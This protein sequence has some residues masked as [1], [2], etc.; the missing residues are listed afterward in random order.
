MK[1]SLITAIY[2]NRENIHS[3][4]NSVLSQSFK[5]IEYIII[6]G[7]SND[8][9]IELIR[10]NEL[11]I[12]KDLQKFI[13]VSEPDSGIYDAINKGI[14]LASGEIIGLL[15]SDDVFYNEFVIEKIVNVFNNRNV[16]SVYGDLEYV[17]KEDLNKVFRY[18]KAGEF[19]YKILKQGWMPPHPT[20]FIKKKIYDEF[21]SFNHLFSIAADYELIMRFL[22]KNKISIAYLPEVMV[23]MRVG[24]ASNKSIKN[25]F[26][27]SFE[28]YQSLKINGIN[29]P[30]ITLFLKNI[31]KLP[32]FF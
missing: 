18:W 21:G 13:F 20:F 25:I 24:G 27:K 7:G 30:L 12:T 31:R 23:K 14:N 8:G 32:Q 22:Y 2:N 9:S 26:R 5:D 28:D 19:K 6:D 11:Q 4:I 16:D 29:T 15:H 3:C 1:I 17:S 10:E